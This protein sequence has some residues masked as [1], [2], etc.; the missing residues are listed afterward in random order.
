[1]EWNILFHF[2]TRTHLASCVPS[3]KGDFWIELAA[4]IAD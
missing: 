1:M 3:C 2:A 4:K